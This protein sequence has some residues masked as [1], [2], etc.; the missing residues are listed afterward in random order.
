YGKFKYRL[1]KRS[2]KSKSHEVKI[3]EIRI[4]PKTDAHDRDT[5]IRQA[6][7]FLEAGD[8]VSVNL[9]FKGR[10]LAHMDFAQQN[11]LAFI[12]QLADVGLVERTPHREGRRMI[13][14]LTPKKKTP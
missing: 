4:R 8:K 7:G 14:L 11:L 13:L 3:K 1:A 5:K 6:R 9:M 12:D 2:R 10:E